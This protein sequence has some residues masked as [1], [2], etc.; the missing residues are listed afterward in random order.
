MLSDESIKI[1]RELALGKKDGRQK[2]KGMLHEKDI[3]MDKNIY[4]RINTSQV[5]GQKLQHLQF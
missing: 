4:G 2:L 5:Y 1:S 3:C